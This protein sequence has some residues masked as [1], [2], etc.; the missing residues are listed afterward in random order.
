MEVV[1]EVREKFRTEA[2]YVRK[3]EAISLVAGL[4]CLLANACGNSR[5]DFADSR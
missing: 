3:D 5:I 2:L 1:N 4:S